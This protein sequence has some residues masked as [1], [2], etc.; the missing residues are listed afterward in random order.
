MTADPLPGP[1]AGESHCACVASL[2]VRT[3]DDDP[4]LGVEALYSVPPE[5]VAGS[6][7]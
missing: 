7:D 6:A 2:S 3:G 5:L 4:P 1:G